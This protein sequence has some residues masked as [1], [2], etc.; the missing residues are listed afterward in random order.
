MY[1]LV[2]K[3]L[4]ICLIGTALNACVITY[5][6]PQQE[7]PKAGQIPGISYYH[8]ARYQTSGSLQLDPTYYMSAPKIE[9]YAKLER[10]IVDRGIPSITG[11][12]PP[13]QGYYFTVTLFPTHPSLAAQ[14]FWILSLVSGF[15]LPAFSGTGGYLITYDLYADG[16][17]QKTYHYEIG[18]NGMTWVALLPFMWVNLLTASERE[19]FQATTSQFLLEAGRDQHWE[20]S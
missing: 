7:R 17:F 6:F 12:S 10:I 15:F 16:E 11:D 8:I 14:Y 18:R 3:V 19:A 4:Q 20:A 2:V 9:T 5:D 1:H 13:T